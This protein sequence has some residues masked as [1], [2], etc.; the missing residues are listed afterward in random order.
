MYK[1]YYRTVWKVSTLHL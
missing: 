1:Q